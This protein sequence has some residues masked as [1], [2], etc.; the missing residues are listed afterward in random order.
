VSH[1]VKCKQTDVG[2]A[3]FVRESLSKQ[4]C[5]PTATLMENYAFCVVC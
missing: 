4:L 5:H 2:V 3:H 1:Y